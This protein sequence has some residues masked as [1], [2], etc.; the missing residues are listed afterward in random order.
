MSSSDKRVHFGLGPETRIRELE[1][2]WPSRT[3]QTLKDIKAE[4]F[5]TIEEGR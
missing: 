4:Q 5:L 2:K 1:I 3:V